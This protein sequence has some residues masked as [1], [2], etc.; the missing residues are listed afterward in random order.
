MRL[1]PGEDIA[2]IEQ[3]IFIVEQAKVVSHP[4]DAQALVAE[5]MKVMPA[6][7]QGLLTVAVDMIREAR[8]TKNLVLLRLAKCVVD[9]ASRILDLAISEIAQMEQR[10]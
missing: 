7:P 2:V 10:S 8:R 6:T 3:I 9:Q 5:L 1:D 4:A